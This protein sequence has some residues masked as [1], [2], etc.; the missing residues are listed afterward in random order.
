M[1]ETMN[2][3][4]ISIE[5]F[6]NE[7][8]MD[9]ED[10]NYDPMMGLG[11]SGI[12][13]TMSIHEL[14]QELGIGFC[15]LR[16]VTMN[17]IDILGIPDK[18]EFGRTTYAANSLLPHEKRDGE[19]G[20]LVLDEI[21]SAS[22]TV[23]AA[24]YQLLDSKRSL[25]EYKLPKKWKVV[26][27]G[28]GIEDGGVYNGLEGAFLS[29]ATCYRVEPNL[30]CW[31]KWAIANGVHPSIIAYFQFDPD[32][33]HEFNP[34][35]F[36]SVFPCPRSW[37]ALSKRL[38]ARE[39]RNGGKPLNIDAVELYAAGT[40]GMK[41]AQEFAAFYQYSGQ[42][43][44]A[45]DILTGKSNGTIVKDLQPE[46]V[47]TAI[48]Q[49]IKQLKVDIAKGKIDECTFSE[50]CVKRAANVSNW[51][52]DAGSVKLDYAITGIKDIAYGISDFG[53]LVLVDDKFDDAC[54]R[55]LQFS[56]ENGVIFKPMA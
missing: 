54:P 43:I 35:E 44:S 20:I 16:L 11:K 51:L 33:L 23:R 30:E 55:L 17:E 13:K 10:D 29:R 2:M 28:N 31:K 40:I 1:A 7:I 19:K 6:I 38:N 37:T 53:N 47:Y 25:G 15:E 12:G 32:G 56:N 14:T 41:K 39:A 49:V 9:L 50:E 22:A 27:L 21:T 18:D 4:E 52:I 36:V 34:D 3:M 26:S 5:R 42:T 8:K 45:E 48:Q 24:A 46:V